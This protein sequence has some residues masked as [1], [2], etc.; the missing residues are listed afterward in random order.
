MTI[1]GVA[2]GNYRVEAT[3]APASAVF[4]S[5]AIGFNQTI[6][7]T[8]ALTSRV[9]AFRGQVVYAMDGVM[10]PVPGAGVSVSGIT[11][12][13]GV[14]PRRETGPASGLLATNGQGCF[15]V[16][17][18][19]TELPPGSPCGGAGV[20]SITLGL[21]VPSVDVRV[22]ATA[23]GFGTTTLTGQPVTSDG[24]LTVVLLTPR[25]GGDR[26]GGD[27]AGTRPR[28]WTCPAPASRWC[29]QRR[30]RGSSRCGWPPTA[31]SPGTTPPSPA[32]AW[33]APGRTC[34]GRACRAT[35][36]A[37]SRSPSRTPRAAPATR[38]RCRRCS[39]ARTAA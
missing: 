24:L 33:R 25:P 35:T 39:S 19:S 32:R 17:P 15:V 16:V 38:S 31:R 34:C 20:P 18:D 26:A 29:A 22:D 13:N 11:G 9:G 10:R 2:P 27:R 37:R 6:S 8:A 21:R 30:V 36:P 12:Y 14:D 5:V 4:D 23:Q 28:R 3:R 1:N 7:L